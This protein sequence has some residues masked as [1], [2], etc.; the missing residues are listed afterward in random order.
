MP[1][2]VKNLS[3]H[4]SRLSKK[5]LAILYSLRNRVLLIPLFLN[6]ARTVNEV[7]PEI[8]YCTIGLVYSSSKALYNAHLMSKSDLLV[9]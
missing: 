1:S 9:E 3:C 4:C 7:D 5:T 6:P 8:A 2:I